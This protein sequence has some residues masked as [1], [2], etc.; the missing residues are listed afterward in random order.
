MVL[1]D[2]DIGD[3][4]LL[5][6]TKTGAKISFN[7]GEHD[8]SGSLTA[9]NKKLILNLGAKTS[10]DDAIGGNY[11]LPI[12]EDIAIWDWNTMKQKAAPPFTGIAKATV[13]LTDEAGETQSLKNYTVNYKGSNRYSAKVLPWQKIT[14]SLFEPLP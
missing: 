5:K 4:G 11:L 7:K 3:I 14:G 9:S 8:Y 12:D 6:T 13:V 2:G 10:R 1:I